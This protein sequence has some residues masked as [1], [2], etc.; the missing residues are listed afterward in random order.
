M[1]ADTVVRMVVE[2]HRYATRMHRINQR[3]RIGNQLAVPSV[4]VPV[5]MT[6]VA[7]AYCGVVG[8]PA[9]V[10]YNVVKRE[11]IL[12]VSAYDIQEL[13][14]GIIPVTAVPHAMDI[15]AR[16]GHSSTDRS[17][18]RESAMIIVAIDEAILILDMRIGIAR[19]Y[20]SVGGKKIGALVVDHIPAVAAQ[21]PVVHRYLPGHAVESLHR[22]AEIVFRKKTVGKL[23]A[24]AVKVVIYH[25]IGGRERETVVMVI[26]G[27]R[28]G[29]DLVAVV[30]EISHLDT[31][32][33]K[34]AGTVVGKQSRLVD[35]L[36]ILCK[37]KAQKCRSDYRQACIAEHHRIFR[38]Y[39]RRSLH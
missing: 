19:L 38:R 33:R 34:H 22:T 12:I 32:H 21:Q 10:E 8:V 24:L 5:E 17:E 2:R 35:E 39:T 18:R 37:L 14:G 4:A 31:V 20:P 26:Y 13:I 15:F 30:A 3:L 1:R 9:H 7:G 28:R 25:K 23:L 27:Q 11:I 29:H 36:A 16:H 6:V